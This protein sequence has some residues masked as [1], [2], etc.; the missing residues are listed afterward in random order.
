LDLNG[1]QIWLANTGA[2]VNWSVNVSENADRPI[3]V[4]P[5]S[6]EFGLQKEATR[7][8]SVTYR[9]KFTPKRTVDAAD[10]FFIVRDVK[11]CLFITNDT[12]KCNEGSG[13]TDDRYD[14]SSSIAYRIEQSSSQPNI[15]LNIFSCAVKTIGVIA[16]GD[17]EK[18]TT[19]LSG[20]LGACK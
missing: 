4:F 15:G 9:V 14:T 17:A 20:A 7:E 19:P 8:G 13:S 6:K 12:S 18:I 10:A 1:K 3:V 16:G 11:Q 5:K 2:P